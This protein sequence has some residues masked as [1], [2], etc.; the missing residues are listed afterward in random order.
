MSKPISSINALVA[1]RRLIWRQIEYMLNDPQKYCGKDKILKSAMIEMGKTNL[2]IDDL[3]LCTLTSNAEALK[4]VSEE[5]GMLRSHVRD[6]QEDVAR[7]A[8]DA[9]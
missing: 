7:L 5:V 1:E 2:A 4:W 9:P 8:G 6:A 3:M